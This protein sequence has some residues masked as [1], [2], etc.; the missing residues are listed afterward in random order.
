MTEIKSID[1][2]KA[3]RTDLSDISDLPG[4]YFFFSQGG[5]IY[6]GKSQSLKS[7]VCSH[8][9]LYDFCSVIYHENTENHYSIDPKLAELERE[10]IGHYE[11]VLNR[12][13]RVRMLYYPSKDRHAALKATAKN[14]ALSAEDF[15][16]LCVDVGFNEIVN[17]AEINQE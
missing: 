3:L 9:M 14:R 15:L 10:Y 4:L 5:I 2:L 1:E 8:K 7:R 11:P 13:G 17:N 12:A 16:A 6:V